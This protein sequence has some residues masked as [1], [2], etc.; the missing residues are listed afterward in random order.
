[1]TTMFHEKL[2]GKNCISMTRVVCFMFALAFLFRVYMLS[3]M[4]VALGWPD[5]WAI[6][7]I[8]FAIPFKDLFSGSSGAALL[9]TFLQRTGIGQSGVNAATDVVKAALRHRHDP[10]K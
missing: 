3:I 8:L 7:A 2:H 4:G 10:E 5:A 6:F 1:M 9:S